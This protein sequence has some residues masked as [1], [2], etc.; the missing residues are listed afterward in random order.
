M[1]LTLSWAFQRLVIFSVA[2]RVKTI[3]HE[4]S[5]TVMVLVMVYP[6]ANPPPQSDV[7]A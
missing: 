7:F 3:F 6:A 2:G 1:P 4:F 5:G